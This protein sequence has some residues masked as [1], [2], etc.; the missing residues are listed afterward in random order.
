MKKITSTLILFCLFSAFCYSQECSDY[1]NNSKFVNCRKCIN[2]N[3]RIYIK[4]KHVQINLKDTLTYNVVLNGGRDYIISFC[5]DQLYYPLHIRLLNPKTK[6]VLYDNS[7]DDY[8]PSI[9][10]G[11][12]Y[13]QNLILELILEP[14]KSKQ[15]LIKP[16]DKICVGMILQWKKLLSKSNKIYLMDK[17]ND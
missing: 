16:D 12:L 2:S 4:Q 17:V 3:Y 11:I 14:L 13:T 8:I 5:A 10:V 7:K 9:G 6:E 15:H 1:H